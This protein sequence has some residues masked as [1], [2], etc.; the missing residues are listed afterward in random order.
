MNCANC[1]R[2]QFETDGV[3]TKIVNVSSNGVGQGGQRQGNESARA[4]LG[5]QVGKRRGVSQ[6]L[7]ASG[8]SHSGIQVT[9]SQGCNGGPC[10]GARPSLARAPQGPHAHM[11]NRARSNDTRRGEGRG[12]GH[13]SDKRGVRQPRR[14]RRDTTGEWSCTA[15][16]KHAKPLLP[17]TVCG[18]GARRW[19]CCRSR[20]GRARRS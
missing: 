4:R 13:T 11:G 10:A 20:G 15:A 7:V 17:L 18:N 14:R 8:W 3:G 12:G 6:K 2:S 19:G 5:K 9:A 16:A 1:A